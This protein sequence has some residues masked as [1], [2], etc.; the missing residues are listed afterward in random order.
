MEEFVDGDIVTFDGL[1]DYE[2]NIVFYS[3]LEYSEAVLDTVEKDG[4]MFYYVPRD[5]SDELV[6]LGTTCVE[7]FNVKERFFHF[8]F[9]RV[10]KTKELIALE[11]NCRPPGGLSIDMWNYSNDF[12]IFREYA[13]IVKDNLFEADIDRPYNVVYISRKA[14]QHYANSLDSILD[15]YRDNIISIQ[16]VPGIFA[17][18]MGEVGILARAETL[19]EMRD[20]IQFAHQKI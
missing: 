7:A 12:D 14:N 4:D 19:D 3:S 18:I 1:T 8:E 9:F 10:K 2:G 6:K 5:I 20:L 13:N 15:K 11:V 17:K 16:S